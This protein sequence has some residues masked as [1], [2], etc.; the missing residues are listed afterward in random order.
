MINDRITLVP[1]KWIVSLGGRS[2]SVQPVYRD[3]FARTGNDSNIS[4]TTVQS[5]LNYNL[6]SAATLY[7]S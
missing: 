4:A 7:G 2:D 6:T 1:D 5:A 3:L